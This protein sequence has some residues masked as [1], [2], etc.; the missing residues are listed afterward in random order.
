MDPLLSIQIYND[1]PVYRPGDS[2]RFDFQIDAIAAV[3]LSAV[4]A[5]IVWTTEG[6][7][8]EDL[9]IHF[10]ERRI[11]TDADGD[12]RSLRTCHVTLPNSPLSYHG[13][14]LQVRWKAR[15]RIFV[16]GGAE[17]CVEKPF[18]LSATAKTSPA[19]VLP[20]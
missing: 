10:F 2:M 15:V 13:E 9:G 17:Y 7:G 5:S 8:D 4:E 12:L 18:I 3:D 20:Q 6:K 19:R 16:R 11:A 14:L 1:P